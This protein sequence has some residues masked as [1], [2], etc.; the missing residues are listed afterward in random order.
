[1]S[2]PA[3]TYHTTF[4]ALKI[5]YTSILLY[6]CIPRLT[7]QSTRVEIKMPEIQLD[8]TKGAFQ[9]TPACKAS[10]AILN[11]IKSSP[12]VIPAVEQKSKRGAFENVFRY[13][14]SGEISSNYYEGINE[15]SWIN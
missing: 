1:M 11:K 5:T 9:A 4:I 15:I 12:V 10:P 13:Y 14:W 7:D 6:N 2:K 8:I 3:N